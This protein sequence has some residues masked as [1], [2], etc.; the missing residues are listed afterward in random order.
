M[1]NMSPEMK[2]G[3]RGGG[4]YGAKALSQRF[5]LLAALVYIGVGIVGFAFTGF[6]NFVGTSNEA[7]LGI[8]Y[9]N[10]FHNVVHIL[11]GAFWLFG[12]L[13]LSREGTEGL[14]IAI[15]GFYV[16]AAVLGFLGYLDLVNV[17]P[18]FDPDNFLHLASG[19]A[20]LLFGSGLFEGHRAQMAAT[21]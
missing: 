20:T 8:F 3:I 14:N 19:A 21:A 1:A 15:G 2:F 12:A 13:I 6:D 17:K 10:P 11:V 5:A 16:L 18:A 4:Q 9:L 7:L